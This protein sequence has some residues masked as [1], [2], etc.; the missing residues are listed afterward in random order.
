MS[1]VTLEEDSLVGMAEWNRNGHLVQFFYGA[2]S[3]SIIL[4]ESSTNI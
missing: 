2:W 3:L 4:A 1:K